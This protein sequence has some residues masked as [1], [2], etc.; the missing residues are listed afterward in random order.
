VFDGFKSPAVKLH[1]SA[2][3][4]AESRMMMQLLFTPVSHSRAMLDQSEKVASL[5]RSKSGC[6]AAVQSSN[7]ARIAMPGGAM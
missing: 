4:R 5:S 3:Q 7:L 2:P 6:F 1:G